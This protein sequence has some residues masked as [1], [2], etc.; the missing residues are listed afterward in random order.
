MVQLKA[1]DPVASATADFIDYVDKLFNCFNSRNLCSK[2]PM[3]HPLSPSSGHVA[4][5]QQALEMFKSIRCKNK[6]GN[7]PCLSGWQLSIT[8]LLQ[9]WD[10]LRSNH[11]TKYLLTARLNHDCL[12]NLFSVVRGKGGRR[13]NPSPREFRGAIKQTTVDAIL[14][15]G[16]GKNC[17]E[18][19]YDRRVPVFL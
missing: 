11:D 9:L 8:C 1:L 14:L 17:Q 10:D 15:T 4:F 2:G 16:E 13:T 7:L 19:I 3:A 12:E 18:D 6:S 5:L